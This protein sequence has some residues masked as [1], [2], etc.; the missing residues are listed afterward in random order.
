[1]RGRSRKRIT[2]GLFEEYHDAITQ[3]ER[4]YHAIGIAVEFYE[5]VNEKME[6]T[7]LLLNSRTSTP[8]K[9]VVIE[10]KSPWQALKDVAE[11][12]QEQ[13]GYES[14]QCVPSRLREWII[15]RMQEKDITET[16]IANKAHCSLSLVSH[17]LAGRRKSDLVLEISAK[18]LGYGTA[19]ELIAAARAC[20]PEPE[21]GESSEGP[22]GHNG[23][24]E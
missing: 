10:G 3:L 2:A 4:M 22:E 9:A 17:F 16:D 8:Y 15:A 6:R 12:V 14:P 23:G 19:G 5:M 20:D 1:M 24:G 18:L 11:Q 13:Y 21:P 7:V